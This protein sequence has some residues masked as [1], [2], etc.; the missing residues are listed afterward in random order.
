MRLEQLLP[1]ALTIAEEHMDLELD[2][3]HPD[4]PVILRIRAAAAQMVMS[5]QIKVDD[6]QFRR[7]K[8]SKIPQ[9]LARLHEEELKLLTLKSA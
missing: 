5:A 1:K 3:K 6:Q 4:F 9:L 7:Q 8:E 2:P